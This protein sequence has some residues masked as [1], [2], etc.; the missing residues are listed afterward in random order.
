MST[1]QVV[2]E[3]IVARISPASVLIEKRV[4]VGP[5]AAAQVQDRL[6]RAVAGELGLG[7]VRVE[8]PQARDEPRLVGLGEQQDPVRADAGVRRAD[9][10]DPRRRQLE[11][12][13]A[14]LEDH[15]VVAERLPLLEVH[16]AAG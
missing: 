2:G 13:R 3:V 16:R 6:A 7:A 15:V 8:D 12:E 10:P 4:L 14:L 11:R 5:A 9:A 1:V